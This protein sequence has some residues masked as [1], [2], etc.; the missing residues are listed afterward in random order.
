VAGEA[1]LPSDLGAAATAPG[2]S[3]ETLSE[4]ASLSPL[5]AARFESVMP[6]EEDA[7]VAPHRQRGLARSNG[8]T[9]PP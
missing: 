9:Q 2:A 4:V 8:T 1:V 6:I 7:L 3:G 5:V